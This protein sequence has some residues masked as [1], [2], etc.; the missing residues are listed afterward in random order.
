[1]TPGEAQE[2][3][4]S[5]IHVH[6][7]RGKTG[8]LYYTGIILHLFTDKEKTKSLLIAISSYSNVFQKKVTMALGMY[9]PEGQMERQGKD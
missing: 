9:M 3:S 7:G 4:P 5:G 2:T 8:F 1:M 6:L